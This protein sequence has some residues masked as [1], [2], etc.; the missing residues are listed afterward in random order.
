MKPTRKPAR[1]LTSSIAALAAIASIT[2]QTSEAAAGTWTNLAGGSWPT[3]ANW[4]GS[5]VASGAD[6][7]ADF[8][9]INITAAATVTLDGARTIGS[10]KFGDATTASHDWTLNTGTGGPLTLDVTAGQATINSVNRNATIGAVLAGNDGINITGNAAGASGR[11][12]LGAANTFTGGL[13]ISG[14]QLQLNNNNAAGANTITIATSANTAS[15]NQLFING[16]VTIANNIIVNTGASPIAGFGAIQN[17]GTGVATING[18]VTINGATANGGHIVGG[19]AAGDALAFNGAITSS[20]QLNQRAGFVRY[21]GGGSYANFAVNGTATVTANNGISSGTNVT[22]SNVANLN[23]T[24]D[25]GAFNQTI[26]TLAFGSTAQATV[27]ATTGTLTVNGDITTAGNASHVWNGLANLGGGS[28]NFTVAD[29]TSAVDITANANFSNGTL[30]KLGAGTASMS[31]TNSAAVVVSGGTLQGAGTYS[32]GL[33]VNTGTTLIAGTTATVGTVTASTL[34]FGAGASTVRMDVGTGGDVINATTLTTAGT[35][36]FNVNQ[37]GGILA[38][39]VTP[40][41]LIGYTGAT[42]GTGGFALT[43]VGHATASIVDAGT[44]IGLLVSAN[45]RVIWDGTASTAWTTTATGNWKLQSNNNPTDY[46]ESDEVIFQDSPTTSTVVLAANVSPSKV[47]FTNTAA[48]SYNF[49]NGAFGITGTAGITKTGNGTVTLANANTYTGTTDVQAGTLVLNYNDGTAR[50]VL[51]TASAISVAG[52]ATVRA[53]ANDSTFTFSNNLSGAGNVEINPHATAGTAALNVPMGGNNTGFT[54]TLKLL[55]PVGGTY[56]ILNGAATGGITAANL[57]GATIEVATGAQIYAAT[58]QTFANNITNLAGTGYLDTGVTGNLG[59]LR[60]EQGTLWTGNI[61]IAAGGARI[62]SHGTTGIAPATVGTISGNISGGPLEANA[63]PGVANI[64]GATLVL[65]GTNSYTTTTVGGST[66]ATVSSRRLNIGAGGTTGTLGSGAVTLN[67]DGHNAILGFDRSDGYTLGAGNDITAAGSTVTR[68]FVDVDTLGN[69]FNDGGRMINLGGSLSTTGGQFRVAQNRAGGIATITGNLTAGQVLLGAQAGFGNGALNI[70]TGAVV[71]AGTVRVSTAALNNSTINFNGG[72]FNAFS[73]GLGEVGSGSGTVNH[74]GSTVN[75]DT[76]LRVGHFGNETS[77]YNISGGSLTMTGASPNLTPSTAGGGS[78]NVTGDNNINALA[79]NTLVGGGIYI[80]VDGQGTFNHT[81]GTVTTNWFVLDNRGASGAG[82]N[83]ADGVD[84]YSIS[85]SA[86]LKLRSNWGFLGR[87]DGSYAVSLGGGTIQVDNTGTGTGT[88]ANIN[89]PLDAILDTVAATTTTLDTNG[90]G[91]GFTISKHTNGTGTL[92]L[93]GGGTVNLSTTGVQIL[94]AGF[95][96]T[97]ALTKIGTGISDLNGVNTGYGGPITVSTGRLNVNTALGAAATIAVADGAAL[98]GEQTVGSLT[99]GSTTGSTLFFD[100]TTSAKLTATTLN[101]PTGTTT[102]LDFSAP[103]P[104][105][106]TYPVLSFGSQTGTGTFAPGGGAFNY[107]SAT[108]NHTATAVDLVIANTKALVWLGTGPAFTWDINTTSNWDDAGNPGNAEK[109]Y[110]AD[111]VTFDDSAIISGATAV[112]ITPGVMP[113]EIQVSGTTNNYTFTSTGAGIAGGKLS[114]D[115]STTLTLVGANTYGGKTAITGGTVSI[116]AANSIGNGAVGNSI[117]LSNGG[118]LLLTTG[119]DLGASRN[120]AVGT[121]GAVI[122]LSNA[123]A[124]TVTIPSN[125]TGSGTNNLSFHSAAAGAGTFVL[126]GD[127]SGYTGKI[128]VDSPS[129]TAAILRLGTQSAIPA[130]GSITL[131]YPANAANGISTSL[132]IPSPGRTLPVG[133]TLNFTSAQTTAAISLRSGMTTG[134]GNTVI[135]GPITLAGTSIVQFNSTTPG[136]IT[137]NNTIGETTPGSFTEAAGIP[138]SAILFLRGTGTHIVNNTVTLPSTGSN[139]SVTDGAVVL[140]NSTGNDWKTTGVLF[141]TM[142]LGANNALPITARMLT[143][144]QGDQATTF[145]LNGFN[146]TVAG[147]EWQAPTGNLLTKGISNSHATATSTFTLNQATA[148]V[149]ANYNGTISGRTNFVKEGAAITSLIAPASTFTGN[150]TVNAGTLSATGSGAA[151][152]ANGTLG[153]ANVVGKTITVNNAGSTL[154]FLTNNIFGNGQA[155]SNLP[156]VT[157]DAG[158]LTSTRYNVLGALTLNG[159][160][161]TQSATDSG[162][163]EGF[164]FRGNVTVGGSAQSVISTGNSKANHLNANTVFTVA[165]AVAGSTADLLVSAPLRNQSGDFASA[166]GGL[167]KDGPGTM[168]LSAASTYTGPTL[169]SNGV[170]RV[171]GSISGSAVTVDGINSILGG[172]GTV[173]ATTLL[174]G[175][176]VNPGVSPGILTIGGNF[177]MSSGTTLSAEIDG[178][179]VGAQYDQLA[180]NGTVTLAG[181]TLSLSGTYLT[182]PT[183]TNDLF[184]LILNDGTSD[185]V[186]GTFAGINEGDHIFAPSGQD[187]IISYAGGDGNDVILTA[188][189]EPGAVTMLLGGVGMLLGLQRRRR[190]A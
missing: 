32:G 188:V 155:N 47:T 39:S 144:Q 22:L 173:G 166:V 74:T 113:A 141:G 78:A 85:G 82:V 80:G 31:G 14:A 34:A 51:N 20:V 106:G 172:T 68:S 37:F 151:N 129:T 63:T 11:I 102:T 127:N 61:V 164:Q 174:N 95:S 121:G 130:G 42:P 147:L 57:G 84:R 38:P 26:G 107:R 12:I 183:V 54:G 99:L 123:A 142:R 70:N 65:S 5:V 62:T 7:L 176:S 116:A 143:G 27:A 55:A 149:V 13:T 40:Y 18:T 71:N 10:L 67:T 179:T 103:L 118:K 93:T 182:T 49:T 30:T 53:I 21:G 150:V 128:S 97:T 140:V 109:F 159:G 94:N 184:T 89:V 125:L 122:S 98:G 189:P 178:I 120:I 135:N 100:P 2:P 167:T 48:T 180:V 152:G 50:T 146:Q 92:D 41:P 87:N 148:P 69:G 169:V 64:T 119:M 114:K 168:E 36:T 28:R 88:G 156:A 133:L 60:L 24:L 186:V 138:N 17:A 136:T 105:D 171:S 44:Y 15:A 45:D 158:V 104:G 91:N 90:A 112:A 126:T 132:D 1:I 145:D 25:I 23:T 154:S 59:A 108:I 72:T 58:G 165:D 46:I 190:K 111:V 9:T 115:G 162:N 8:S 124:Q 66:G 170:L 33:T 187:F 177:T 6:F 134:T 163:Y 52:G 137:Y 175:G 110:Q 185:A 16:G 75:I 161:L 76:Q 83:M 81:G 43:P 117:V 19:A 153:A 29:G 3:A 35:T 101:V 79:A 4:S 157:I 139:V 96:G 77:T 56:R 73:V 131:N 86:L 160:T 181:S